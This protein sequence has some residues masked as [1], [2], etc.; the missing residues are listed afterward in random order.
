MMFAFMPMASADVISFEIWPGT[1]RAGTVDTYDVLATTEGFNNL[2][3]TIPMGYAFVAPTYSGTEIARFDFWNTTR[4]EYYG[5]AIITSDDP[6]STRVKVECEFAGDKA[7]ATQD[8]DYRPGEVTVVDSP[9]TTDTSLV[10]LTMP[11]DTKDGS[12]ILNLTCLDFSIDDFMIDIHQFVRNPWKP[13]KP[14][15]RQ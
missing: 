10:T 14:Q 11:K 8:I 2:T 1:G 9:F 12:L 6:P 7:N 3:I 15:T 5:S 4:S 13:G